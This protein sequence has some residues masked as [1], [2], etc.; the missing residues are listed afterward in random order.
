MLFAYLLMC[1]IYGTTFLGI[2]LG[3]NAGFSPF[4][5]AGARFA[6]ASLLILLF[7]LFRRQR[8][9]SRLRDYLEMASVGLCMT[10]IEFA[11]VYWA[12]QFVSS[13]FTALLAASTPLMVTITTVMVYRKKVP[14]VEKLGMLLGF[15]GVALIVWP[16]LAKGM[17][18]TKQWLIGVV[19]I[20]IAEFF[21]ALGTVQARHVID[22]GVSPAVMNGVQMLSGSLFLFILS[23][24]FEPHP[25][26]S[27]GLTLEAI[28]PLLYMI[29]FGS[30]IA[31][32]IYYWLVKVTNPLFPATWTYVSPV[33]AVIVG[34]LLLGETVHGFTLVGAAV[35]LAGVFLTNYYT[36]Q[37]TMGSKQKLTT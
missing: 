31:S 35:V 3:L 19:I 11:A 34:Y 17:V 14:Q 37:K 24:W 16:E 18:V 1:L 28:L 5:Y 2:K 8:F 21:Y 23:F 7:L 9:P 25:L 27:T 4:W 30:L 15:V 33:I 29:V 26:P 6:T 20:L 36:W 13:S 22:R 10:G 12:E 32:S